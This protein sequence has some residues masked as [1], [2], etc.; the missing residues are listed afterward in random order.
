MVT[1]VL[2]RGRDE[3]AQ[4]R[5]RHLLARRVDGREVG[6]RR[7]AVQVVGLDREAEAVLLTPQ[8]HVRAGR[9]LVLQPRLVEPGGADLAGAVA[10]LRGEDL[11][12]PAAAAQARR[13]STSPSIS[14]SSSPNRSEIRFWGAGRSYRRGRCS[15]RSPTRS[16]PSLASRFFSV[17]PTPG[18]ESSGASSR[19]GVEA[20]ARGR[21]AVR[22]VH[23]GETGLGPA[24][25]TSM[26]AG[27]ASGPGTR[28]S[29]PCPGRRGCRRRRR[30]SSRA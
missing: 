1:G 29:R 12:P 26:A 8:A 2:E 28:R 9:E 4:L 22:R 20:A 13:C 24:H 18:S 14:T 10:D 21:P 23:G 7:A 17:G 3:L 27:P 25:R 11:Q 30:G 16:S 15:S 6:G 19:S 5:R